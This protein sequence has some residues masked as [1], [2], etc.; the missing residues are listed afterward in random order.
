MESTSKLGLWWVRGAK[1]EL[2]PELSK[3]RELLCFIYAD[4]KICCLGAQVD[5]SV[6]RMVTFL[7]MKSAWS[8]VCEPL[9]IP[10]TGLSLYADKPIKGL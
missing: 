8:S 1:F 5:F 2:L 10:N 4:L 3:A 7:L 6:L 9:N